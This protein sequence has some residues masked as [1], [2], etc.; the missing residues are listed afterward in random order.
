MLSKDEL[1]RYDRQIML[2][3]F[4]KDGQE[5][6]K[7]AKVIVA[8][9]GGLGSVSSIYL[10]AAGIGTIRIIDH[11]VVELSNLNR[12]IAHWEENIGQKKVSSTA[13]KLNKLNHEVQIDTI[14]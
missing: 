11:D 6:L 7:Q 2:D 1:E 5:K 12:Q 4:G 8:G 3:G 13:E 10:T 14:E 9:A